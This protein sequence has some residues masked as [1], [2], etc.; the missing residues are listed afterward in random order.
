MHFA[1]V[2]THLTSA[3]ICWCAQLKYGRCHLEI[4]DRNLF[5]V[6]WRSQSIIYTAILSPNNLYNQICVISVWAIGRVHNNRMN[7]NNKK[8]GVLEGSP[9]LPRIRF[10][11]INYDYFLFSSFAQ[12]TEESRNETRGRE[13]KKKKKNSPTAATTKNY[14]TQVSLT[15]R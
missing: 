5:V 1:D 4:G 10:N 9:P 14:A 13:S 15:T 12:L 7:S 8:C 3:C 11:T 2:Y 6:Y